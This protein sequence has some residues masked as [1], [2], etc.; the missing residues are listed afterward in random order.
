MDHAEKGKE[1]KSDFALRLY[2]RVHMPPVCGVCELHTLCL[3][4]SKRFPR[5]VEPQLRC[6]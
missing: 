4:F 2:I 3:G 6:S 5:K 1:E